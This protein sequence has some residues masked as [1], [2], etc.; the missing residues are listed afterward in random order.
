MPAV[1]IG[2]EK[3]VSQRCVYVGMCVC[4]GVYV[5]NGPLSPYLPHVDVSNGISRR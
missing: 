5:R 2:K 1:V 4:I 3:V